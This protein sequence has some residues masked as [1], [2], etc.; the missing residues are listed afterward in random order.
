MNRS[1]GSNGSPCIQKGTVVDSE[2]IAKAVLRSRE[3]QILQLVAYDLTDREIAEHLNLSV[4]TVSNY[5]H[6]ID[7][8]F[9]VRSRAGAV[10]VAITYGIIQIGMNQ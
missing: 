9:Q 5:L 3:K 6:R 8:K 7:A 2:L 1:E 10:A 4:R